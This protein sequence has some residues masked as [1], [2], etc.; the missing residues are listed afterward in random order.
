MNLYEELGKIQFQLDRFKQ[1]KNNIKQQIEIQLAIE[2]LKQQEK[3]AETA[4]GKE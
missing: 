3:S 2:A 4:E 1:A